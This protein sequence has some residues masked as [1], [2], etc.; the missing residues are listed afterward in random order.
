MENNLF[1]LKQYYDYDDI[2]YKGIR[3]VRNLFDLSIDVHYYKPITT[4]N[5]FNRNYI[6][7]E[8]I[9]DKEKIITIK[10]YLY[11]IRPHLINL[12][13]VYKTQDEWKIQLII[14]IN[15]IF[16]KVLMRLVLCAQRI[17]I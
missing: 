9:E 7:Y 1:E 10:K 6:E 16:P 5:A 4:S 2:K 8:S 11:M 14:A 15:Y 17:I 13:N 12:I 3:D